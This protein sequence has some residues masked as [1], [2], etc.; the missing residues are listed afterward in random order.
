[1][2]REYLVTHVDECLKNAIRQSVYAGG[3]CEYEIFDKE[4]VAEIFAYLKNYQ[5]PDRR[6]IGFSTF[7]M[8][9]IQLTQ[10]SEQK[11]ALQGVLAS[12][13]PFTV[14]LKMPSGD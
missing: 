2:V 3:I 5:N 8:G 11:W 10:M 14:I 7:D 6:S 1:M 4:V 9:Q 13:V 12:C